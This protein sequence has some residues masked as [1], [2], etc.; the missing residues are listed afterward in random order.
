MKDFD[1]LSTEFQE[2]MVLIQNAYRAD[3][4]ELAKKVLLVIDGYSTMNAKIILNVVREAVFRFSE[5]DVQKMEIK[6]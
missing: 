2:H 5:V 6:D 3:T 4:S 1:E